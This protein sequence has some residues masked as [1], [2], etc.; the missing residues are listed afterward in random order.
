M[1]DH[2]LD[3]QMDDEDL[4]A[5]ER[6]EMFAEA[7]ADR[8]IENFDCAG[9]FGCAGSFGGTLGSVGTFGCCC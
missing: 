7:S 1:L 8:A 2:K 6:S 5:I 4:A 3:I 9:T